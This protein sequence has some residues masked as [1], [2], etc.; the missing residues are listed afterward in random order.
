MAH[1]VVLHASFEGVHGIEETHGTTTTWE[2]YY[3]RCKKGYKS[4]TSR[5]PSNLGHVT[6]K[7]S[8]VRLNGRLAALLEV[9]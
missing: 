7:P 6:K 3:D 9:W 1:E 2:W 4:A 5:T 8:H